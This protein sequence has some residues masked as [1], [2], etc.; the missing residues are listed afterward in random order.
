VKV[1][2]KSEPRQAGGQHAGG[3]GFGG[4]FGGGQFGAGSGAHHAPPPAPPVNE[5]AKLYVAYMPHHYDE[6]SPCSLNP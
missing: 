1:R 3:G 2:L 5:E 6:V 4:H